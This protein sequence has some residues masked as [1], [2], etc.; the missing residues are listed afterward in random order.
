MAEPKTLL[1]GARRAYSWAF[2][3][4]KPGL[5]ELNLVRAR[6]DPSYRHRILF[7]L[8]NVSPKEILKHLGSSKIDVESI[9]LG[10]RVIYSSVSKDHIAKSVLRK[11]PTTPAYQYVTVR[12]QNTVNKI[13]KLFDDIESMILSL[14]Q[15]KV[16]DMFF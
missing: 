14:L 4:G 16:M 15:P 13:A 8:G 2:H 10:S 12:N 9:T 11:F 7:L 6:K 5:P 3:E 1:E